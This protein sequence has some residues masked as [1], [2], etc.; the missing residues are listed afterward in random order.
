MAIRSEYPRFYFVD[1]HKLIEI[2]TKN[3]Y[4]TT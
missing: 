3:A 4:T 1:D 2:L